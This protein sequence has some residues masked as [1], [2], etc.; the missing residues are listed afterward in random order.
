[1][2]DG[3]LQKASCSQIESFRACPRKWAF[4]KVFGLPRPADGDG[5]RKGKQGHDAL[6]KYLRTGVLDVEL[7]AYVHEGTALLEPYKDFFPYNGGDGLVETP[8]ENPDLK[9]DQ[10]EIEGYIDFFVPTDIPT[11]IDHKFKAD[12]KRYGLTPEALQDDT[13]AIVYS[14]W[15][16][17]KSGAPKVKFVHHNHQTRGTTRVAAVEVTLARN[18]VAE[19]F[20]EL[21]ELVNTEIAPLAG[22]QSQEDVPF[23]TASCWGY[24]G[25]PYAQQCSKSPQN[26]V[27]EGDMKA[28]E[29]IAQKK[30][31]HEGVEKTFNRKF[32]DLYKFVDDNGNWSSLKADD[33]VEPT[34]QEAQM[35]M[36][37]ASVKK[38]TV[39]QVQTPPPPPAPAPSTEVE[40]STPSDLILLVD[41]VLTGGGTDLTNYVTEVHAAA[42][43][44]F[45]VSDVRLPVTKQAQEELGFGRWKAVLANIARKM[46]PSGLCFIR[47]GELENPIIEALLSLAK[48]RNR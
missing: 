24:G 13:Q 5:V 1:M 48:V 10:I 36:L 11:V 40:A 8:L 27:K 21:S 46:P 23:N 26:R 42:C 28:S 35:E 32:R 16:F 20:A 2:V 39:E 30:Y 25:C 34:E 18:F 41:V 19:K 3:K 7:P 37:R 15:A 4:D 45:K 9:F 14:E 38:A 47:T 29:A 31:M 43:E 33:E 17:R 12:I 6:E 44:E 22:A